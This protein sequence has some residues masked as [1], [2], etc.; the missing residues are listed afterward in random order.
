MLRSRPTGNRNPGKQN[1]RQGWSLISSCHEGSPIMFS[2]PILSETP[3]VE[4]LLFW[5]FAEMAGRPYLIQSLVTGN[6]H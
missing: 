3:R 4:T 5:A 6:E 1:V 2:E